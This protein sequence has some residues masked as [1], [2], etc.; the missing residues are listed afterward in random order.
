MKS[1]KTAKILMA[2]L[3]GG[4]A[5]T[6]IALA[7]SPAPVMTVGDEVKIG[8]K[9]PDFKLLDIEGKEHRL[10]D[11][12]AEGK[13]VVLEWFNPE[14]PFVRKHHVLHRTMAETSKAFEDKDVVWLAI[15]SGAPGKQGSGVEANAKAVEDYEIEYP[16]LLDESGEVGHAYGAKTTPHMFVI[17]KDGTLAYM[18]AIDDNPSPQT[19][20]ETNYV[21][22]ALTALTTG[23][24]V[25]TTQSKPYGCGV[26]YGKAPKK[27][28]T[29]S[30][31]E[32]S[33]HAGS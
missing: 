10:A 19:V 29:A 2:G 25:E 7:S 20:G 13:I 4:L 5:V 18:G 16:L 9:A 8:A 30:H 12:T 14:C 32:G 11:Y 23:E 33:H 31:G 22:A 24:S 21:M 28:K 27:D 17:A 3:V 26:K 1:L 15:N 6:G